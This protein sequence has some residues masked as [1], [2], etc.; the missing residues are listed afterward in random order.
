MP[1]A[2]RVFVA[3]SEF[4]MVLATGDANTVREGLATQ[5]AILLS[6]ETPF[7][8]RWPYMVP[9][10]IE[11]LAANGYVEEALDVMSQLHEAGLGDPPYD[12]LRLSPLFDPIREDPR[13]QA[14]EAHAKENFDLMLEHLDR[15]REDGNW[16]AELE[17]A[18]V[19]LMEQLGD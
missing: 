7:T 5:M 17:Q 15:F 12:W 18:R 19:D 4:F 16:P 13:F 14:V 2:Y 8:F 6:P 10:V 1:D 11:A 3:Q 9:L